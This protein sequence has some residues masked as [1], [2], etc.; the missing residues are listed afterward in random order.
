MT[1]RALIFAIESYPNAGG[2]VSRQL[3]GTH[4][5]GVG[6]YEW[7]TTARGVNPADIWV[8]TDLPNFPGTTGRVRGATAVDIR[9]T[10]KEFVPLAQKSTS[11][12]LVFFSGHGFIRTNLQSSNDGPTRADIL[13]AS[14][15]E[16]LTM[17]GDSC[18]SLDAIRQEL[19]I[20][21][22]PG[23][24]CYF[25]DACRNECLSDEVAPTGLGLSP[26]PVPGDPGVFMLFSTERGSAA[27]TESGFA[28]HLLEGLAGTGR[29]KRWRDEILGVFFDSLAEFMAAR[30]TRQKVQPRTEP[31]GDGLIYKIEPVPEYACAIEIE[32]A[33]ETDAFTLDT[34]AAAN[35]GRGVYTFTGAHFEFR[36]RPDEYMLFLQRTGGGVVRDGPTA[37]DLYQDQTAT[38]HLGPP[39]APDVVERVLLQDTVTFGGSNERLVTLEKHWLTPF[40]DPESMF[41]ANIFQENLVGVDFCEKMFPVGPAGVEAPAGRYQ[42]V[43]RDRR[44]GSVLASTDLEL[45]GS[46]E[47]VNLDQ[48]LAWTVSDNARKSVL[49]QFPSYAQR[50]R[51]DRALRDR[52][53]DR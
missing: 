21:L 12:L 47:V 17:S 25:I 10:F 15:F 44:G 36:D 40:P 7:L 42:V 31:R 46:G 30:M 5:A 37:V 45:T 22:G 18:F 35:L 4:D 24:H 48:L 13:V 28:D 34:V 51:L 32:G 19:R 26:K 16:N 50:L 41:D 8:N 43:V 38:F 6:F 29:A 11:L 20:W 52:W 3:A 53:R 9:S 2:L 23:T 49:D 39:E 27:V 33:E 1:I 14:D